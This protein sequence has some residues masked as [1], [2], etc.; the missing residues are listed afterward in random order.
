MNAF[1]YQHARLRHRGAP[2]PTV[3]MDER[4]RASSSRQRKHRVVHHRETNG[5]VT[6]GHIDGDT[7]NKQWLR[8]TVH[9]AERLPLVKMCVLF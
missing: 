1:D 9:S 8:I 7:T 5:H 4:E 3:T 2:L 6:D